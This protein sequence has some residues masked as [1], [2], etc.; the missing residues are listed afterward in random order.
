METPSYEGKLTYDQ[1]VCVRAAQGSILKE[2]C[3]HYSSKI[4]SFEHIK[5]GLKDPKTC[6]YLRKWLHVSN[7][8]K[9]KYKEKGNNGY[10]P[11]YPFFQTCSVS[12]STRFSSKNFG[13]L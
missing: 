8:F 3:S 4:Q 6:T 13:E 10:I 5:D 11:R 2:L 1:I 7:L 12:S 9:K